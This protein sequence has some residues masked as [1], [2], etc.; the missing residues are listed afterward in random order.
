MGKDPNIN[1]NINKDDSELNDFLHCWDKFGSRPNKILIY[2]SF[3]KDEFIEILSE[4]SKEKNVFTEI[5]PTEESSIIND[6][7]LTMVSESL[8]IS[9]LLLDRNNENSL[10]HEITFFSKDYENELDNINEILEKLNPCIIDFQDDV[11]VTKLNTIYVGQSGLEIEPLVLNE[12]D[13]E[14]D[15]YYNNTSF[16]QVKKLIKTIKRS[17]KGLSIL[18]GPRG[19]GKTSII[20]HISSKLDRVVIYIPNN[21][22]ESTINNPEFKRFLLKHPKPVIVLDDCEVIFNDIYYKSNTVVNN[23]L[24]IVDGFLSDSIELNVITIFNTDDKEEID[25]SLLDCNN[26]LDVVEFELLDIEESN[27]LTKHLGGRK[28]YKNKARLIDIIKKKDCPGNK[29]VGF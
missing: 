5:I 6:K 7:V 26:L 18:Y 9:Y 23:L 29:K 27:E 10:I 21:L 25:Q 24:Q 15:M 28:K 22:I 1:I 12:M 20:S 16:K 4:Y 19:C 13:T 8:Y 14:L 2:N 11:K 3:S 17:E